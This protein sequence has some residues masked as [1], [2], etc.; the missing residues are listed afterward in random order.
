VGVHREGKSI[1]VAGVVVSREDL[2]SAGPFILQ[3]KVNYLKVR[4]R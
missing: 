2:V 4:S 3:G 1:V